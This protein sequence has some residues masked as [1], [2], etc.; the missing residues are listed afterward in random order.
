[1]PR[2]LELIHALE[3]G[4]GVRLIKGLASVLA[5][6]ALGW[7]F[8]VHEF[9]NFYSPEAM[10]AAHVARNLARGDGFATRCLSPLALRLVEEKLG[11]E[12]ALKPLQPDLTQPPVYPLVLAGLMKIL[13]FDFEIKELIWRY[14][15]EVLIAIF[16]QLLFF[17]TLLMIYRLGRRLFDPEVGALAAAMMAVSDVLWRFSVSGLSTMLVIFWIV[18]LIRLLVGAEEARR[19]RDYGRLWFAGRGALIGAVLGVAGLTRYATL[20]L[21]VPVLLFSLFYLRGA[22][23]VFIPTLLLTATL[24]V[25]PWLVRNYQCSGTLFGVP[26]YAPDD[27]TLFFRGTRIERSMDLDLEAIGFR[28][29]FRKMVQSGERMTLEDLPRLGGHWLGGLFLAGLMLRFRNPSVNR[30]RVFLLLALGALVFAQALGR[31]H[32]SDDVREI[33]TENLLI[34]LSPLILLYGAALLSVI[35]DQ[36]ELPIPELRQFLKS[37]FIFLA[38]V[39]LVVRFLPPRQIPISYPPYYP[40]W[41]VENAELIGEKEWMLSDIPWAVAWYGERTCLWVPMKV[42]PDFYRIN[43]EYKPVAAIYLTQETTNA[44][45]LAD[46]IQ[47]REFEWARFAADILLRERLPTRF[48]LRFARSRYLPDQIFL[49]DRARWMER[50]AVPGEEPKAAPPPTAPPPPEK[51][52]SIAPELPQPET[53]PNPRP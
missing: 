15:P 22:R 19:L 1:M 52:P 53:A 29:Y 13:P 39:P 35:L 41:I 25:A 7:W 6:I 37:V 42:D 23:R 10:Q 12:A 40:K 31:T 44:R 4:G 38:A 20:S 33:N 8:D 47:G 45:F 14:Q 43:D 27:Q 18:C 5:L 50:K 49:C 26:G 21:L 30:L 48:P 3:L 9:R 51:P 46:V 32:L 16:N 34:L 11:R 28:D 36:M 17:A 2:V 24:L